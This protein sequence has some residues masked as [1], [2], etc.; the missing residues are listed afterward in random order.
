MSKWL[1]LKNL[2]ERGIKSHYHRIASIQQNFINETPVIEVYVYHYSEAEYRE[3]ERVKIVEDINFQNIV[4][5]DSY[6]FELDDT[7]G[8]TRAD[9]YKRMIEE[10]PEYANAEKI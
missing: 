2:Y 7:K 3:I 6:V 5:T 1:Y 4:G 8:A 9:F 10:L